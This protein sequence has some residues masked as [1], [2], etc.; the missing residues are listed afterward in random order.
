M[1]YSIEE[2]MVEYKDD[3]SWLELR[4]D[5]Y[6]YLPLL[7]PPSTPTPTPTPTTPYMPQIPQK[8]LLSRVLRLS[9]Q[10]PYLPPP[11]LRYRYPLYNHVYTPQY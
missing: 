1:D 2:L 11:S 6:N 3:C 7:A 8:P 5:F 4:A 9:P 10:P